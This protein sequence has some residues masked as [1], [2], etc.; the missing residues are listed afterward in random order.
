VPPRDLRH[1]QA[2]KLGA[3]F[4]TPSAAG[5]LALPAGALYSGTIPTRAIFRAE[6]AGAFN[7]VLWTRKPA[8]W[9]DFEY[10]LTFN[11]FTLPK[12]NEAYDE[13]PTRRSKFTGVG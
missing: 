13:S 7:N 8:T 3:Q 5:R 12:L 10:G 1:I 2:W 9:G 4:E 6:V 11:N